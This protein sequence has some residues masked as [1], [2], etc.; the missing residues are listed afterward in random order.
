MEKQAELKEKRL[1]LQD[2]VCNILKVK[3]GGLK[4]IIGT[5]NIKR[6]TAVKEN[7]YLSTEWFLARQ[8]KQLEVK[9]AKKTV[10]HKKRSSNKKLS[11]RRETKK[12]D[13]TISNGSD[14]RDQ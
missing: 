5:P 11:L 1:Q 3:I 4:K 12:S 7:K 6:L 8:A 2:E 10:H 9:D 13:K 14:R